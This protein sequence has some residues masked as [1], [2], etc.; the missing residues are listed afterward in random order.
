MAGLSSKA[1]N[2]ISE[3]KK[4]YNGNEIQKL[5]FNGDGGLE[6]YDFYA[7]IYDQQVG[8]FLESDPLSE[9]GDQESLTPYQFSLNNPIRY[10]DPDGKCPSCLV[11]GLIG[12]VVDA[13]IQV[14]SSVATSVLN[15][16]KVTLSTVIRDYNGTQ[17]AAAFGA[18]FI[19]QGISA[20]EQ[21]GVALA[22]T[23]MVNGSFSIAGQGLSIGKVDPIKTVIDMVP[24]PGPKSSELIN[25][26]N[27]QTALT[28]AKNSIRSSTSSIPER[29]ITQLS[30]AEGN[31]NRVKNIN[32]TA[33]NANAAFRD[34]V[35]KEG[36]DYLNKM[37]TSPS[38][39]K[40]TVGMPTLP[41]NVKSNVAD[42]TRVAKP[43]IMSN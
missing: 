28:Q 2:G 39:S 6:L 32:A 29:K 42:N 14:G 40:T 26:S 25:P 9:E 35:L 27:A 21:G 16:E 3:N 5:E 38:N 7:R 22:K 17:G 33:N 37:L 4:G 13:T 41:L 8:R 15:G 24:L 43:L 23:A 1:L 34:G 31:L 20:V 12:L 19:T 11:G 18:G 10:N 30:Q 36:A